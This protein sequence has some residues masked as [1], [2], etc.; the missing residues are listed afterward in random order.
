VNP[1]PTSTA[2]GVM[3]P[4]TSRNAKLAEAMVG[5]CGESAGARANVTETLLIAPALSCTPTVVA[6]GSP[7]FGIATYLTS[8]MSI[9]TAKKGE[10]VAI[11]PGSVAAIGK[12]PTG[13]LT[14]RI[15]RTR[16]APCGGAT[17]A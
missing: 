16:V 8:L 1:E 12:M 2:T 10:N 15:P 9:L 5:A 13:K 3:A 6:T 7:S 14:V 4:L 17:S 11:T